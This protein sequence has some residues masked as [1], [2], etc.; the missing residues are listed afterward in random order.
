MWLNGAEHR[1]I[2]IPPMLRQTRIIGFTMI[3]ILM[4]SVLTIQFIAAAHGILVPPTQRLNIEDI[5]LTEQIMI[6][7]LASVLH[8]TRNK[9]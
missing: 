1:I 9:K 4:I 7:A 8:A 3:T 6:Q 2:R 5:D